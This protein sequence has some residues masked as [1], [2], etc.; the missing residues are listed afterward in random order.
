M[1]FIEPRRTVLTRVIGLSFQFLKRTV[2]ANPGKIKEELDRGWL[3][4]CPRP[5]RTMTLLPVTSDSLL[6]KSILRNSLRTDCSLMRSFAS[7]SDS[8]KSTRAPRL[9]PE[10]WQMILKWNHRF[11]RQESL[12]HFDA[13]VNRLEL[14][15]YIPFQ[16]PRQGFNHNRTFK[17]THRCRAAYNL[18]DSAIPYSPRAYRHVRITVGKLVFTNCVKYVTIVYAVGFNSTL[19]LSRCISLEPTPFRRRST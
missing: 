5:S 15:L 17:A 16:H 9:P 6:P 18:S 10:V 8:P 13:M 11:R 19:E 14:E 7:V 1:L 2:R 4:S 3:L 12:R